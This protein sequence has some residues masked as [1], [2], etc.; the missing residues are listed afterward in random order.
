MLFREML[1]ISLVKYEVKSQTKQATEQTDF[2]LKMIMIHLCLDAS[3]K[4]VS[5][6]E[7]WVSKKQRSVAPYVE[8]QCVNAI[9]HPSMTFVCDC[10][11][12]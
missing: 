3:A 2:G 5:S 8:K 11:C 6:L 10:E 4:T 9:I 7:A 12:R 1:K